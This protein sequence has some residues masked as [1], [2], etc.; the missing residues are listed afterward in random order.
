M[1]RVEVRDLRRRACRSRNGEAG[2]SRSREVPGWVGAA[3]TKPGRASTARWCGFGERD[4]VEYERNQREYVLRKVNRLKSGGYG[5]GAVR[6]CSVANGTGNFWAGLWMSVREA[7]VT[8]CGVAVAMPQ[9]QSWAPP[10][11]SESQ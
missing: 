11:S 2:G 1:F 6:T 4:G 8:C 7:T 10:S 9:G 5:L 3:P